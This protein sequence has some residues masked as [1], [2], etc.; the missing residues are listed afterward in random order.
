MNT[1]SGVIGTIKFVCDGEE[2]ANL[3]M[4]GVVAS[5]T[6]AAPAGV[7]NVAFETAAPGYVALP[8]ASNPS[9]YSASL[10]ARVASQGMTET[11]FQLEV[12]NEGG[13]FVDAK[14]IQVAIL[15]VPQ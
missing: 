4:K 1:P 12:L 11:G 2:L 9:D 15:R 10:H 3:E 7:F 14:L 8:A 13:E 6:R 5:V